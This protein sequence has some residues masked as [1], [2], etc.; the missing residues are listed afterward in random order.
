MVASLPSATDPSGL[1]HEALKQSVLMVFD[2]MSLD[3]DAKLDKIKQIL[4]YKD[5]AND[6]LG[7]PAKK[8]TA[9]PTSQKKTVTEDSDNDMTVSEALYRAPDTDPTLLE[10]HFDDMHI[11]ISPRVNY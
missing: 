3:A 11:S 10:E 7:K 4:R 6:A 9:P 8:K 5:K 2:D 1:V